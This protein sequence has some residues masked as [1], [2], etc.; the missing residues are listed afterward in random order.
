[1]TENH[2][3]MLKVC[4]A[5]HG[6]YERQHLI[7]PTCKQPLILRPRRRLRTESQEAMSRLMNLLIIYGAWVSLID[8]IAGPQRV[9]TWIKLTVCVLYLVAQAV[10]A[11]GRSRRNSK[12]TDLKMRP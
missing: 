11:R 5:C 2:P 10:L 1:M 9:A 3:R 7:C 6:I 8:I 4:P 12:P